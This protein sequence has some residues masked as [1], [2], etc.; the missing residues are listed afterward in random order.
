M[1]QVADDKRTA[2]MKAQDDERDR[3]EKAAAAL[4]AR[5]VADAVTKVAHA[6]VE[7]ASAAAARGSVAYDFG[8][9]GQPGS[10]FEI[11]GKGFSTGGSVFLNGRRLHTDEWGDTYIR[12]RLDTDAMSGEVVIPVDTQKKLTGY[13]KV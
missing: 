1:P 7:G 13:L 12:G 2:D 10:T 5:A 9:T 4:G 6:A 11:H 8:V 3:A